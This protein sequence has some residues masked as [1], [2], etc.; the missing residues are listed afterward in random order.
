MHHLI[1]PSKDTYTTNQT[2]YTDKNFGLDEILRV[3]AYSQYSNVRVYTKTYEYDTNTYFDCLSVDDFE[4]WVTGAF[5]G[6]SAQTS[7]S[8]VGTG[9]FTSSWFTGTLTGSVSGSN[10]N[11]PVFYS[12]SYSG[13]LT[14]FSGALSSSAGTLSGYVTSSLIASYFV[15]YTGYLSGSEGTITGYVSGSERANGQWYEVK[16]NKVISRAMLQFDLDAISSSIVNGAITNPQFKLRLR[17][18]KEEELPLAY[19]IY[20]FP[21]SQSW[22]PGIGYLSDGGSD[23]GASWDYRDLADGTLWHTIDNEDFS[24]T[25]DY[26]NDSASAEVSFERGGGTWYYKDTS[27][28]VVTC[29][30]SFDY[31]T[32]DINMNVTPIVNAWLSGSLPNNGF[33]L[34]NSG[35]NTTGSNGVLTLFSRDTNTI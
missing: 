2:A 25:S 3:G 10:N 22:E 6:S 35:E 15:T 18:A 11:G 1:F 21:V 34:L 20:A 29:T 12:S 5:S 9:M 26:L 24:P 27:N 32:S 23:R 14:A 31:E 33:I 13:S 7:G 28:N 19:K 16:E 8:I 4:G 17:V 30:Q